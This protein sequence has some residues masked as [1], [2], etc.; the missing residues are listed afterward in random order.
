METEIAAADGTPEPVEADEEVK[1]ETEAA[2]AEETVAETVAEEAVSAEASEEENAEEEDSEE[3]EE[4]EAENAPAAKVPY[5]T[6]L[7]RKE[8]RKLKRMKKF[9]R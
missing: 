7:S 3:G 1:E 5:H 4:E 8:R 2:A 6:N 9:R